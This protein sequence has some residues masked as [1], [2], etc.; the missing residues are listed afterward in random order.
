MTP[1]M[2]FLPGKKAVC[3]RLIT[4]IAISAI[5][6]VATFVN[7]LKLTFRRQMGLYRWIVVAS[8]HLGTRMIVPMF[9]LYSGKEPSW[10]S[11]NK[12]IKY[13]LMKF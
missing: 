9:N 12:A 5:L 10:K 6:L 13:P 4:F 8:Q 2:I 11:E 7:I 1:S 3:V